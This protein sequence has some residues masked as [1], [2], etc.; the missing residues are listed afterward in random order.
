MVIPTFLIVSFFMYYL[1]LEFF[2]GDPIFLYIGDL[3]QILYYRTH[4]A[5]L[6]ALKAKYGF[7]QPWYIQWL[8]VVGRFLTGNWG[9]SPTYGQQILNIV[10]R[11][12]PTTL[13]FVLPGMILALLIGIPYGIRSSV[14]KPK[15]D[16]Y[17]YGTSL[18]GISIP[19]FI[20]ALFI[21]GLIWGSVF[22]IGVVTNNHALF[23][24]AFY[25]GEFNTHYFTYPKHLIFGLP[26]TN[27]LLIDSLLSLNFSL[28][29]D[30]L[31]H[32]LGPVFCIMLIVL[33][34]IVR[35][36]RNSMVEILKEDYILL[37]KSKGLEERIILYKHA[38][39]NALLPIV[40][41]LSYLFSAVLLGTVFIE[42]VFEYPGI[43]FM[44][45]KGFTYFDL[46]LI[47]AFLVLTSTGFILLNLFIDILYYF[48][49][50]R[51]KSTGNQ[52]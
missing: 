28:F 49:D 21:Q 50:P 10:E 6:E 7:N 46:G 51:T 12:L 52:K 15:Q 11:A 27:F 33:P 48:I 25:Q 37:A 8:I 9:Y 44:L 40:S 2:H 26:T 31:L 20:V 5:A 43:G 45:Y 19:V 13:E 3:R 41:Y 1:L 24:L 17:I 36:T 38:F 29:I 23:N 4:P 39:R 47:L 18:T 16:F 14:A 34:F 42:V 32:L 22:Y 35:M 30:A